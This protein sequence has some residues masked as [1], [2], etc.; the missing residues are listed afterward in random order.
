MPTDRNRQYRFQAA[1]PDGLA[2]LLP[3][4]P[5]EQPLSPMERAMARPQIGD[6]CDVFPMGRKVV[7]EFR[8]RGEVVDIVTI[9]GVAH[10]VFE[11]ASGGYWVAP[12]C[13]CWPRPP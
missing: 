5:P 10:C 8:L 9:R 2:E 1:R 3:P 12:A 11:G 7:P 13:V 4:L 6:D